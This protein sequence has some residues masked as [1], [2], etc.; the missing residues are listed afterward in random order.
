[1]VGKTAALLGRSGTGLMEAASPS[2]LL[3]AGSCSRQGAQPLLL[4]S[5]ACLAISLDTASHRVGLT[6]AADGAGEGGHE[7]NHAR[8][9]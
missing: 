7:A 2:G 1:M 6:A 5:Q 9:D 3:A 8:Q 4:V